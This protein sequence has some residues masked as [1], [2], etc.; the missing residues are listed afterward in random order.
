VERFFDTFWQALLIKRFRCPNCGCVLTC[1]PSTHFSRIQSSKATVRH[2]LSERLSKN[3]WPAGNSSPR[4]RHWLVNLK[5]KA[6]AYLTDRWEGGLLA[7]YDRLV[8]MGH[9]PVSCTV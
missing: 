2:S 9:I 7:A 3:R 5:R 1:R 6:R 4:Q 8:D